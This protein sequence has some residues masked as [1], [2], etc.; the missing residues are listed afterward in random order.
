MLQRKSSSIAFV[1]LVVAPALL[2]SLLSVGCH[3]RPRKGASSPKGGG[4]AQVA[5]ATVVN[6]NPNATPGM[7]TVAMTST[8]PAGPPPGLSESERKATARAAYQEGLPLQEGGKCPEALP[9][10]EVA[11]KFFPA[12]THM[13][14]LAQCEAATGKLV[15]ASENYETLART[16]VTKETPDA[17]KHAVDEAKKEGPP[18]RSRV[19]TLR[20]TLAPA[21]NTIPNLQ[22]KLNG[23]TFPIEVLGIAR[24][25]NP[26]HYKVVV[27]G[28]GYRESSQEIEVG[29][30]VSKSMDLKLTK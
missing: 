28:T 29:E 23:A 30:S 14:H 15:E 18:L 7:T 20:I 2:L 16:A 26:G 19:P 11:Q 5:S 3:K 6:E 12:P 8:A 13:L 17:F 1:L 27:T 9:K 25:V 21:P 4:S 24:P 10:F 22:V